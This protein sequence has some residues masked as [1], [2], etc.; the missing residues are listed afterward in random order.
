MANVQNVFNNI[1][2]VKPVE[3]FLTGTRYGPLTISFTFAPPCTDDWRVYD[4]DVMDPHSLQLSI[5]ISCMPSG[6]LVHSP[7]TCLSGY[8][9]V[10]LFEY[11]MGPRW[12]T[13]GVRC[14]KI[15]GII[16]EDQYL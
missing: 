16:R 9:M 7:S 8:T 2:T 10:D 14:G 13:G 5:P 3:Y 6:S 15:V 11:R 4:D 1:V 12:T